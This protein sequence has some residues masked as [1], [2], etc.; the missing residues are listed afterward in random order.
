M[1]VWPCRTHAANAST[2][3]QQNQN[4]TMKKLHL[5]AEN[6]LIASTKGRRLPREEAT[7]SIISKLQ[8]VLPQLLPRAPGA[9]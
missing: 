6:R 3:N 8:N 9:Q 1:R 7:A 5:E 2:T 4:V